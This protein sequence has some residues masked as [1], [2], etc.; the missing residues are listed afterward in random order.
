MKRENLALL[1]PST[2]LIL[3]GRPKS[4][5]IA[6]FPLCKEAGYRRIGRISPQALRSFVLYKKKKINPIGE[7]LKQQR[8]DEY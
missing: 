1:L 6:P 3:S 5:K 4:A 2:I 7:S 8:L